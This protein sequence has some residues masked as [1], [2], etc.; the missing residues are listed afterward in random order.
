MPKNKMT[1]VSLKDGVNFDGR[2]IDSLSYRPPVF[3]DLVHI[4]SPADTLGKALALISRF[5][6]E[7]AEALSLL[8]IDDAL[9]AINALG[10]HLAKHQPRSVAWQF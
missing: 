10:S 2:Q 5:C 6:G 7:P 4:D 8:T 3:A 9:A 1:R